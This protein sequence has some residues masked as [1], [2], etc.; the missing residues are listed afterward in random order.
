MKL[1]V[2]IARADGLYNVEFMGTSDPYCVC[3]AGA[4]KLKTPTINNTLNPVWNFTGEIDW[5]GCSDMC[6]SLYDANSTKSDTYMGKYILP[7][8]QVEGGFKG[9]VD[10]IC[11][12]AEKKGQG[13]GKLLIEVV[14]ESGV[15]RFEPKS[16]FSVGGFQRPDL[17]TLVMEN[18][19]LMWKLPKKSAAVLFTVDVTFFV[20]FF[21]EIN[22]IALLCNVGLFLI[23]CGG[24]ARLGGVELEEDDLGISGAQDMIRNLGYSGSKSLSVALSFA[25]R[26]VFWEDQGMSTMFCMSVYLLSLF[27]PYVSMPALIFLGFNLLFVVPVQYKMNQKTIDSKVMPLVTQALAKKDEFVAKIPKYSSLG[28][29][30]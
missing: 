29:T 22:F 10:L 7:K 24:A 25:A 1:T 16:R 20:Y 13:G 8:K 6:F 12:H 17:S 11:E 18:D 14:S 3:E 4:S 15:I 28:K 9:A 21:F 23:L 19:L 2:T 26:I 5:D 27:L 30:D